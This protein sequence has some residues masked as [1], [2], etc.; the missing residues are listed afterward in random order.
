M[1]PWRSRR[2]D[3]IFDALVKNSP[4]IALPSTRWQTQRASVALLRGSQ[5]GAQ[6]GR[7]TLEG[8][9]S[10]RGPRRS[11]FSCGSR[12]KVATFAQDARIRTASA[13]SVHTIHIMHLTY[14]MSSGLSRDS[15]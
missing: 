10:F 4:S 5:P 11:T 9:E 7:L 2:Q 6:A 13:Q 14:I 8:H 3:W 1:C 12:P 15:L